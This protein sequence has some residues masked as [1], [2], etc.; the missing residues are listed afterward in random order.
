M[1]NDVLLETY[2]DCIMFIQEKL[3][4]E[5]NVEEST[6]DKIGRKIYTKFMIK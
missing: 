4:K 2:K 5:F 1:S 3:I 6:K